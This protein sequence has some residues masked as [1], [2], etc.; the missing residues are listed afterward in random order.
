MWVRNNTAQENTTKLKNPLL[1]VTSNH[2]PIASEYQLEK[3]ITS[4]GRSTN[5]DVPINE[6]IISDPHFQVEEH[7]GLYYLVHPHPVR[8]MWGTTNGFSYQGK[9]YKGNNNFKHL[10]THGDVFRIGDASGTM[11]SIA[12]DDGSEAVRNLP[13]RDIDLRKN[14]L[15]LG[16]AADN[17]IHLDHE[18]VSSHHARLEKHGAEYHILDLHSTNH[19]YVNGLLVT[20]SHLR[21][22]DEIKIG[23]FKLTYYGHILRYNENR[24][25][26]IEA[27]NLCKIIS[28]EGQERVL[29]SD[30]SLVIP[31]RSFVA[32]VGGSG[33]GKST[34]LRA[35]SGLSPASGTVHYNGQDYYKSYAAFSA[36][37]GYVPQDD[38]VHRE[39]TVQSA[40]TYGAKLRLPSDY[41]EAQIQARIKEVLEEVELEE[42]KDTFIDKLSGGQRK[43]VSIALELLANPSIFFLDEPTSGLDPGLDRKMMNL[44]RKLADKGQT[45]VLA[46]HATN[47]INVCDYVCFLGAGRLI[48]FGP[49]SQA[50]KFFHK[51]DF[52]DIY[53]ALENE[54]ACKDW[55]AKFHQTYLPNTLEAT[56]SK[57]PRGKLAIAKPAKRGHPLQQWTLLYKRYLE[58]LKNDRGNLALLLLQAPVIA[59]LVFAFIKIG[60]GPGGF[61]TNKVVQC[62]RTEQVFTAEGLPDVPNP[63]S[64]AVSKDCNELKNIL[65][66]T[67]AGQ[68]YAARRGGVDEALQDFIVPGP[69]NA[70]TILF[71][72]AF[73]AIMC[74]CINSSREI[75]KEDPIYRRERAVNVGIL[76]YLFSKITVLGVL[77]LLQS[78]FLVGIISLADPFPHGTFLPGW[79][80]VYI[81]I[82]LTSLAG[83]ALGLTISAIVPNSDRA[84]SF[85]P[86]LL[87]PQVVFSGMLFP[88]GDR[89]LQMM[90]VAFP[91]RWA[92]AALGSTVGMHGDKIFSPEQGGDKLFGD[93]YSYHGTLFSTYSLTNAIWHLIDMWLA[94]C[95]I[96]VLFVIITGLCLKLKDRRSFGHL[97]RR[98]RNCSKKLSYPNAPSC[99]RCSTKQFV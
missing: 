68:A 16:R 47:N 59:L 11:V 48:Y 22:G 65:Q 82:A 25:I 50:T 60:I 8:A 75:V 43:R 73:A 28:S 87:L 27:K 7:D 80:E 71:I 84:M 66:T 86:L 14:I 95:A 81:T 56:G 89:V 74:G 52:A 15:T 39:L 49:P 32:L 1:R 85:L 30:I 35:L 9:Q 41:T 2:S 91:V 93:N 45:I 57:P 10:L 92:M 40:L 5:C 6:N 23:P 53:N 33:A 98:C 46:T 29:L 55:S 69:G 58:L 18:T 97:R 26:R 38:I 12:F 21:Q 20:S 90:G 94:L 13:M 19:V 31:P 64:T 37:L 76:P 4:I 77:C 42:K 51:T 36:Q 44:L 54:Q 62:P 70:A 88:L 61:D 96:I 67:P 79:I 78:T 72:M 17:D 63:S 83:L 24:T 99:K 3:N 34:L